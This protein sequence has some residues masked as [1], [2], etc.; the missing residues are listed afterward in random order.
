MGKRLFDVA[1]SLL[2]LVVLSPL[3]AAIGFAVMIDDGRPVFYCPTRVG[4]GGKPFRLFKF[5]TMKNRSNGGPVIT[6]ANDD[7]VTATGRVLRATKADE[8]P[9]LL[10]VL[11]GDMSVV[12]PRP[13]DPTI[14]HD[15]YTEEDMETLTVRPGLASPGSLYNYVEGESLLQGEHVEQSYR[16]IVLP[17]KLRL[18]L[19]YVRN[20]SAR[21][22]S[23]VILKTVRLVSTRCL[24]AVSGFRCY[25]RTRS[26][27]PSTRGVQ[28]LSTAVPDTFGG[29]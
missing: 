25:G 9:Q 2:A 21:L 12:G 6:G 28:P 24:S 23:V 5:R 17:E 18:E 14:V 29:R 16:D 10:N 27:Q 26:Y 3:F 1:S 15:F 22:D 7:R 19:D 13:E 8:L 4:R 20:A 11:L